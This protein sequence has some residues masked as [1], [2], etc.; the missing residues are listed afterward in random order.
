MSP[1][2]PDETGPTGSVAPG[3]SR[4]RLATPLASLDAVLGRIDAVLGRLPMYRVVSLSLAALAAYAFGLIATDRLLVGFTT[5]L[6]AALGL[7]V[8]VLVAVGANAAIGALLRVRAHTESALIT[9]LLLWFILLPPATDAELWWFAATAFAAVASKYVIA[10]RGR[11]LFNPAAAGVVL[12]AAFQHVTEPDLRIANGWWIANSAMTWPVALLAL[13]VLWR[14]RKVGIGLT[15]VAVA[16]ALVVLG[17]ANSGSA[18]GDALSLALVSSPVIFLAGF[19]LSEPLTLPPRRIQ[20][21]GAAALAAVVAAWPNAVS[22]FVVDPGQPWFYGL[23]L[24]LGLVASGIVGFVLGQRGGVRLRLAERRQVAGD[25][26]ELSFE[27]RR[28]VRFT[29]GQ[30]LELALP[31]RH[32]DLR[33]VRRTFS[34]ASASGEDELAIALRVPQPCSTYKRA[35]LDLEPGSVLTAT[36]VGGDFLLR[37]TPAVLIAGGIGVTPFLSQLRSAGRAGGAT[38]DVVL[39]Y[40]VADAS[41]IPYADEIAAT[42]VAVVIVSPDVPDDLPPGWRHVAAALVTAEV[43]AAVVPDLAGR[44][45]YVSGPPAMVAALRGDLRGR[46]AGIRTDA[47]A[48]Y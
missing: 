11:H 1:S 30:H 25:T 22:L 42:G 48:G 33:G 46:T 31:H 38:P 29:P 45:A 20:Q 36:A 18:V 28:R 4:R 13:L 26:W 12:I 24:E 27:P 9:G 6:R 17:R 8:L 39:V 21:F 23:S 37:R 32:A 10:V 2:H 19:M 40:G 7:G 5:P 34:I 41:A 44:T 3:P 43:V 35:L 15:F 14:I 47:F 16:S